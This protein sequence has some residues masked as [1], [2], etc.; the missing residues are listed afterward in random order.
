[1]SRITQLTLI[2]RL[3]LVAGGMLMV[4]QGRA[5]VET[6]QLAAGG[7]ALMPVVVGAQASDRV[8][9]AAKTLADH[10]GRMSGAEFT[11]QDGDGASGIVVGL[12]GD[13]AKLQLTAD[14]PGGPFG[15]E[16]YL[17]RSGKDGV[18]LIGAADLGVEHAVWDLLYRLGHRQFFPGKVWEV[19]PSLDKVEINVDV[20]ESPDFYARRIWYNWGM[21]WGYNQQPYRE[22][23][24]RNRHAQG[25]QLNSGH[26]YESIIGANK[27]AF[28][29]HPE[30][31]SLVNGKR[32]I[33][34]DAKFCISNP[35]LRQLVADWAVRSVKANPG[36]DSISMDPSD[37]DNWCQ[38][39]PC[40]KMGSI[41]DRAVTLANDVAAAINTLGLGNKYVGMYAYNRH[42]GPPAIKVHP[43][44]VISATTAF[45]TGGHTLDG[46]I[47]GWQAQ[48][49]TIGIY[50]YFSVVDWD[51]NMPGRAKAA[52]PA[53]VAGSVRTF[54]QKGARF[55][56]CESGDAW[57]PYGLGY[58]I[59]A[60]VM[61]DIDEADRVEEFTDDFLTK[62]FGP[63]QEPMRGFYQLM[64]FDTGRRPMGDLLG[65]L[66]RHLA[67]AKKLAQDRPEVLARL[68][69]LTLYTRY[70]ELNNAAANGAIK[71]EEAIAHAYRMRKT[72]MLHAY[73]YWAVTVGQGAAHTDNHPLKSEELFTAAEIETYLTEGI[74]KNLP[75]EMGFTPVAFSDELVPVDPLKLPEVTLGSFPNESQDHHTYYIWVPKAPA[76][77]RMKVTVQRKWALRPHKI[78]LY[79][80]NEVRNQPVAE[81]GIVQPDG[82]TYDVSLPTT[83]EGLHRVEVIDG[84]DLTRITWP[85]GMPVVLPS[86]IDHGV[87]FSHFRGPWTMYC[88]V[89]K[90]TPGGGRLGGAY[91]QL[92]AAR[93]RRAEGRRRQR[94]VRLRQDARRRLVQRARARG[95]GWQVVEIRGQPGRAPVDDRAPVPGA[96][97][98]GTAAAEGSGGEG[99]RV[100][101]AGADTRRY[102]VFRAI[103]PSPIQA[104]GRFCY[105][106]RVSI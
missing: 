71:R 29:A 31:Y 79:S 49:A 96:Q 54:Y 33:G 99:R 11:V 66:Y 13:F 62:A 84:G 87:V 85:E 46:I 61:W 50:D 6:A 77:V 68:T 55:Y 18:W 7:K 104:R 103:S 25:F 1:M 89:P 9:A 32:H 40:A 95:P 37:G 26:A 22:W 52:R 83:Y 90:G 97:W 19:T 39:E 60:R 21:N 70:A 72:M 23:C 57:G 34:G 73:G 43:N 16:D 65:R 38:C 64:N 4:M 44:V 98:Q 41:S 35:G 3:G 102:P 51:W 53:S 100:G 42:C 81:S 59:G 8:R 93:I 76:D 92:G 67:E 5:A 45:I 80:P 20:R 30:Y 14:F 86:G 56:D 28:D 24:A 36:L 106:T 94:G 105:L 63:A 2:A 15:R 48:G 101:A 10:L 12:L 88:Y 27:A 74:A 91:R 78:T 75:V 82:Q 47:T 58:Y 69:D 17:L